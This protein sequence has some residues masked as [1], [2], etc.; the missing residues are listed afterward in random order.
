MKDPILR[1][2]LVSTSHLP[3]SIALGDD[4]AMDD[5]SSMHGENGWLVYVGASFKG[6]H[7]ELRALLAYAADRDCHYVMFDAAAV[8]LPNFPT[9]SW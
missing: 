7:R 8:E 3:A 6:E 2:L 5:V 1:T 4:P 9:F